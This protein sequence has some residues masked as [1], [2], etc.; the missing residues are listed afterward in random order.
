MT[1]TLYPSSAAE[2]IAPRHVG[3][4]HYGIRRAVAA[5]VALIVVAMLAIALSALVG[6]AA[7]IGG[8]PAAASDVAATAQAVPSVHVAQPGDTLWSIADLYRG[9]VGQ[10]RF[11][12]ALV[13]LNGGASIQIGQAVR[14][15]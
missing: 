13:D 2:Q 6:A 1:A 15:P 7:D 10:V 11:V 8:R 9:D 14:L 12:D 5:A 4:V 3:D